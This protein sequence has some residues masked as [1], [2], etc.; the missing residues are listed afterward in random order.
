MSAKPIPSRLFAPRRLGH[1]NVFVSDY[2]R[3]HDFYHDVVGF[4]EVYRQPDNRASFISNGNTYHDMGLTDVRSKYAKQGQAP[5]LFH[6]A[7]ELTSEHDLV[8]GY[9]RAVDAGVHFDMTQ[10]HD[11]A[12]S[13]YLTDPDGNGV[14]L[15]ADVVEDWRGARNGIIVKKKPQWIPGVTNAPN[16]STL[17]PKNPEIRVVRDSLFR[18]RRVTHVGFVTE[19]HAAQFDYYTRVV[20]LAPFAGSADSD[21]VVLRGIASAGDVTLYR[22]RAGERAGLHH[23]GIEV[24]SPDLERARAGLAGAGLELV[25]E[26]NHPARRVLCVRDPDGMLLQFYCNGDWQPRNLASLSAEEARVLL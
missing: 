19:N 11:V 4:E 17:H 7:F 5:G 9:R 6:I 8:E 16:A 15:Y 25:A 23:L 2:E 22:R 10:D 24:T 21:Y 20:G 12:H 13:L 3:I 14:E 1:A 18:A 26:M